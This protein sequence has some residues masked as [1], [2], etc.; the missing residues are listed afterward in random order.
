MQPY[1]SI[2]FYSLLP[3]IFTQSSSFYLYTVL[4]FYSFLQSHSNIYFYTF[5]PTFIFTFIHTDRKVC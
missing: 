5:I 1:F 4:S 2:H 3:L